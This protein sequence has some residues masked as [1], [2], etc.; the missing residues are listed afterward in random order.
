MDVNV[1][2]SRTKTTALIAL[3]SQWPTAT[4]L[5][6]ADILPAFRGCYDRLI[7][8]YHINQRGFHHWKNSLKAGAPDA[9]RFES[10]FTNAAS[11]CDLVVFTSQSLLENDVHLL[12]RASTESLVG[13]LMQRFAQVLLDD[14][15]AREIVPMRT[16]NFAPKRP[17]CYALGSAGASRTWP[18]V[19]PADLLRQRELTFSSFGKPILRPLIIGLGV[20]ERSAEAIRRQITGSNMMFLNT[21]RHFQPDCDNDSSEWLKFVTLWPF[22]PDYGPWP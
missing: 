13:E 9:S 21:A 8:H 3:D 19:A 18:T 6:W 1:K 12:A 10:F 15:V 22:D 16:T 4:G 20:D 2:S 7:G 5:D 17:R 11:Q 14:E